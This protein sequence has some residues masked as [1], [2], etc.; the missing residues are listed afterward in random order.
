MCACIDCGCAGKPLRKVPTKNPKQINVF[1]WWFAFFFMLFFAFQMIFLFY[2][3]NQGNAGSL[4]FTIWKS[5]CQTLINIFS[6]GLLSV[7]GDTKFQ[8]AENCKCF[9]PQL[10][11]HISTPPGALNSLQTFKAQSLLVGPVASSSHPA[12]ESAEGCSPAS[13]P[14]ST[15]KGLLE[16]GNTSLQPW[17]VSLPLGQQLIFLYHPSV[18]EHLPSA[19]SHPH[20]PPIPTTISPQNIFH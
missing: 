12:L 3:S 6:P 1:S 5:G 19:P 7:Q 17:N 10:G 18:V 8:G 4:T 14:L 9:W 11:P 16:E 13:P 2:F 20:T 15:L